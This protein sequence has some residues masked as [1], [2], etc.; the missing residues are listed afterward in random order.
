MS[1]ELAERITP[2]HPDSRDRTITILPEASSLTVNS[3]SPGA[4]KRSPQRASV[5]SLKVPCAALHFQE[6][7]ADR[8]RTRRRIQRG[9][10]NTCHSASCESPVELEKT[11]RR[12]P[13]GLQL[14]GLTTRSVWNKLPNPGCGRTPGSVFPY[15]SSFWKTLSL[16]QM[17][18]RESN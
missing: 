9:L 13:E 6:R 10:R 15:H 12:R 4:S 14:S 5:G 3:Y 7:K 1:E 8:L 18:T 16:C 17:P 11:L 2:L